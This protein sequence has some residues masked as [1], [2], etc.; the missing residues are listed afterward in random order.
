M[1][2][3]YRVPSATQSSV[4]IGWKRFLGTPTPVVIANPGQNF[5]T[6]RFP[7]RFGCSLGGWLILLC[8]RE[9]YE[10][11]ERWQPHPSALYAPL[12]MTL[13]VTLYLT[14]GWHDVSGLQLTR[15]S[16]MSLFQ[17]GRMITSCGCSGF[18]TRYRKTSWRWY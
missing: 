13:G 1:R 18:L 4:Q 6:L 11:T 14:V 5:G 17:I 9:T 7:P 8:R 16:R 12:H 15:S 10:T 3:A 2:S